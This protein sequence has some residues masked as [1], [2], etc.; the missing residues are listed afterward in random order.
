MTRG[1]G[2]ILIILALIFSTGSVFSTDRDRLIAEY[3]PLD[4]LSKWYTSMISKNTTLS[5]TPIRYTKNQI[6]DHFKEL[7]SS[8]GITL[9]EDVYNYIH[10]FTTGQRQNFEI[11]ISLEEYYQPIL[12]KL[13][14]NNKLPAELSYLPIILSG[15]HNQAIAPDGGVGIWKLNYFV[16]KKYGLTVNQY[17]DERKDIAKSTEAALQ[18]LNDLHIKYQDWNLAIT[19]FAY[20]PALVNKAIILSGKK[21]YSGINTYLHSNA[22][23]L[24]PS[25]HAA[26][27]TA[28]F[29]L[30]HDFNPPSISVVHELKPFPIENSVSIVDLANQLK[31]SEHTLRMINPTIRGK[32]ISPKAISGYDFFIPN[33][34]VVTN[35]D[36]NTL[37]T[38]AKEKIKEE[39]KPVKPVY[40]YTPPPVPA[41]SKEIIYSVKSGDFLGKIAESHQVGVTSLKRWNNLHSDRID[42]GQK[43]VIYVP[44]SFKSTASS[45]SSAVKPTT[46]AAKVTIPSG[47]IGFYTI[48][49]G[50]TLWKISKDH[51][52][53][54]IEVIKQL[55]GIGENIKPG[56]VLKFIKQ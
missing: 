44:E 28:Q 20:S 50:D 1:K 52:G 14:S 55:N 5:G 16:A 13:I 8:F 9:N 22:R 31:I 3:T 7:N 25:Y 46:P 56:Q 34:T 51:P 47:Q 45:A 38:A 32:I 15:M 37:Y 33:T 27:Y 19:A 48:K 43:L 21:N 53:N 2:N 18:Y 26:I 17:I 10:H 6:S 4:S 35:L 49:E 42:I 41:N 29:Y 12:N 39:S 11:A 24:I 40:T 23:M 54:S 30:E 36:L